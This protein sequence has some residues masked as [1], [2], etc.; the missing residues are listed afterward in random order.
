MLPGEIIVRPGR[1]QQCCPPER[2]EKAHQE[3]ASDSG[4]QAVDVLLGLDLGR[5]L[6]GGGVVKT[7][8]T[9][10]RLVMDRVRR[11]IGILPLG[12]G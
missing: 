11:S 9:R 7:Q 6:P 1:Y 4:Q 5:E 10:Q 3:W 12:A 8:G 2:N